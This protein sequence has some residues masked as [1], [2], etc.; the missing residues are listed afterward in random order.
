MPINRFKNIV[1]NIVTDS[2]GVKLLSA[3]TKTSNN[4]FTAI[5]QGEGTYNKVVDIRNSKYLEGD[6]ILAINV[7][8][9]IVALGASPW[10]T[11]KNQVVIV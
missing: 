11:S 1:N 5:K 8:G 7:G 6:S 9:K 2:Y 4:T 3:G 10:R